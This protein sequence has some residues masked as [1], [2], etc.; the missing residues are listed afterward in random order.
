MLDRTTIT[1]AKKIDANR[2]VAR[3]PGHQ[4]IDSY[5][6]VCNKMSSRNAWMKPWGR[7]PRTRFGPYSSWGPPRSVAQHA[8]KMVLLALL[9]SWSNLI[10][11]PLNFLFLFGVVNVQSTISHHSEPHPDK[12]AES[13]SPHLPSKNPPTDNRLYPSAQGF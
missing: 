13:P 7:F 11:Y 10:T 9:G 8:R 2:R 12:A 4:K 1:Q 6:D 3:R 5:H